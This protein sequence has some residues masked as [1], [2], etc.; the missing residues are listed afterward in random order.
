MQIQREKL[1]KNTHYIGTGNTLSRFFLLHESINKHWPLI[2][3]VGDVASK[4]IYQKLAQVWSIPQRSLTRWYDVSSLLSEK[5]SLYI[6]DTTEGESYIQSRLTLTLKSQ[7]SQ[8]INSTI[9]QLSELWYEFSEYQKPWT[10]RRMGD[11]LHIRE[12]SGYCSY[13]L[14]YW[15]DTIESIQL[16][17]LSWEI[18]QN[19]QEVS[20]II[21]WSSWSILSNTG[22][23]TLFCYLQEKKYTLVFDQL[24][25][26]S[27]YRQLVEKSENYISF[28]ILWDTQKKSIDIQRQDLQ[29]GT[30]EEFKN[31]L[32]QKSVQIYIYTKHLKLIQDFLVHNSITWVS[33]YNVYIPSM[34]SFYKTGKGWYSI[35]CDDI[36]NKIFIRK[37]LKRKLSEDIDLLLKI[38]KWDYV[39]HIDH[40][41]GVFQEI[42][43]KQL[44]NIEKEYVEIHYKDKDKLF[45]PITEVGRISKYVGVENPKLTALSGKLWEKKI[46]KIQEDIQKIAEELLQ[47]Y[48]ERK[49]RKTPAYI[50]D[51]EKTQEFQSTF[52]YSYTPCQSDAI[53]DILAD[54]W[55]DTIMD[56]LLVGDVGFWKTE[57]AFQALYN[58]VQNKKQAVFIAPLVVLAYEHYE[59]ALERFLDFGIN[60]EIMTRLEST[61]NITRV[62][63]WLADGSID[64]VIG[65]HKI[66]GK[67]IIF[68]DLWLIVIDEEH[69][70]WVKDKEKIQMLKTDVDVL[71]LSAT[72]IPRSLNMALSGIRDISL[73]KTP[74]AGRKNIE[75][76]ISPYDQKVILDAGAKEFSRGGQI[77]FVHNRVVNLEVYKKMLEKLFP[78][79]RVI[80]THGQLPGDELENRIIAFK[81]KKYDILLSTTVI[82]NGI[83]FSNV[84]TIFIN[85]CQNFGISQLHQLRWRVGRSDKKWYCYL[86]Y[87]K[88]TLSNEN[89]KRLQTLVNYNYL[90]SGFELAM[91]DLEIRGWG[92]ILGI[93]QSGQV[94]EIGITLFLK[95]LE[96]KIQ[97]L[98]EEGS[99]KHKKGPISSIDLQISAM[100]PDSF[101]QS[102]TDKIQFYREIESISNL[103][104]LKN[105]KKDFMELHSSIPKETK[106]FFDILRAKIQGQFYSIQSIKRIWVNYQIDFSRDIKLEQ[107]KSFLKLDVEVRFCVVDIKRIRASTKLFENDI[108]FLQYILDMFEKNIWNPKIKIKSRNIS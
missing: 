87:K 38:Q 33:V 23:Q 10:Y 7:E 9:Q 54:M 42:V 78:K 31:I 64:I 94:Q 85:E 68:R 3:C 97:E 49:L 30:L 96:E 86:L 24:E 104:E 89:A 73:L 1:E 61:K 81:H 108:K 100:I 84:N 52:P 107:L 17:D 41:V 63:K 103:E 74:P 95:M 5:K 62:K 13:I 82:E 8:D 18:V 35:I 93:R 65:T 77:F 53:A 105:I 67:D 72:P 102:E 75:T 19:T 101:F 99:K 48:A 21:L 26:Y 79:K 36:I 88:D 106:N 14:S 27:G 29:I 92:D 58:T 91:K 45:V 90:W 71:C 56:R 80:I 34:K 25:F 76:I 98:K 57:V 51:I 47:T 28:D 44:W 66:L 43:K 15:G 60:I 11:T 55:K 83:D 37:R 32:T 22:E 46:S 50:H 12:F 6:I 39:I 2:L 4:N 70:F 69:K 40:G 16:Q 59:K 20:T